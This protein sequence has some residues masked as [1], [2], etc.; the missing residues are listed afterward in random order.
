MGK[1]D[2][3]KEMKQLYKAGKEPSLVTVPEMKFVA[4]DGQGDPNTSEEYQKSMEV[5]YGMAYTIKF[6][7]KE[8]DKDFVVMPLEGL[9]WTDDMSDFTM[10]NKDIWKWTM[11]IALPDYVD[12]KMFEEARVKLAARKDLPNLGKG[13]FLKYK[14]GLCAQVLHIGPYDDEPPTIEKLHKFIEDTGY[15]L[16]K[17]HKE[18]YLSSP[19]RTAPE[20]LKTIIRQPITK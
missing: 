16:H 17:K 20:K 10:D 7:C 8:L 18:V 14:E 12:K 4:Y 9:W 19:L 2:L 1:I 5:L 15:K 13:Y 6:M 11:M 3:K